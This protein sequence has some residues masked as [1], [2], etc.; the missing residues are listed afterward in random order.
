[1]EQ[2]LDSL[3]RAGRKDI[4]QLTAAAA[5]YRS[6]FEQEQQREEQQRAERRLAF[7]TAMAA[8]RD[9]LAS[10]DFEGATNLLEQARSL[11]PLAVDPLVL[12]NETRRAMERKRLKDEADYASAC[13]EGAALNGMRAYDRAK[14]SY[15]RALVVKPGST[16]VKALIDG[17]NAILLKKKDRE[18]FHALGD[19]DKALAQVQAALKEPGR[20][21]DVELLVLEARIPD[22][23]GAQRPGC[24]AAQYCAATRTP[25]PRCIIA[26]GLRSGE[27]QCARSATGCRSGLLFLDAPRP[28][29]ALLPPSPCAV[30]VPYPGEM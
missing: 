5:E 27:E 10:G 9:Q 15:E 16:E 1:M 14:R 19:Q 22:R 6:A 7:E 13:E 23:E 4:K 11:D 20:S 24:A 2:D 26:A 30:A 18:K 8:A 21:G 29:V 17:L 3:A 12:L 28:L 25:L